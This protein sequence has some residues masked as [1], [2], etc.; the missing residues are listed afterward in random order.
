MVKA[1]QAEEGVEQHFDGLLK[2]RV[3]A[4]V[5]ASRVRVLG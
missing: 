5:R 4:E 1:V 2:A 3:R